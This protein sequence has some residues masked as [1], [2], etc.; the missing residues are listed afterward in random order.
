[1]EERFAFGIP[2]EAEF[3]SD[4]NVRLELTVV[5]SDEAMAEVLTEHL[6]EYLGAGSVEIGFDEH[7]GGSFFGFSSSRWNSPWKPEGP[8][9][10]WGS[11]PGNPQ[12]N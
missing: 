1:M 2:T 4:G 11:P 10:N 8:K 12:L 7:K 9:K 6:E 3:K 5:A